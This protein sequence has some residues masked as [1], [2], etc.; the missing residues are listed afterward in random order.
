MPTDMAVRSRC[1]FITMQE[2]DRSDLVRV[3]DPRIQAEAKQLQRR[4]LR[5]RLE[6]LSR[7]IRDVVE[8]GLT[9]RSRD[10]YET[11]AFAISDEPERC[12]KLAI[13]LGDREQDSRDV[14]S[15]SEAA[16]V[17]S[18]YH[19]LHYMPDLPFVFT[20]VLS[21]SASV[22]LKTIGEKI[23]LTPHMTGR[24]LRRLGFERSTRT[25]GGYAVTLDTRLRR[26]VH[27]LLKR[28]GIPS[29]FAKI[30]EI[31]FPDCKVCEELKVP[32]VFEVNPAEN[33]P[34]EPSVLTARGRLEPASLLTFVKQMES[35]RR[36]KRKK[37]S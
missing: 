28:Y 34:S 8:S 3:S 5:L 22:A 16:I 11:L 9:S 30:A 7:S 20:G 15:S 35:F 27:L 29:H 37:A 24:I 19:I 17:V 21:G 13:L 23:V 4:F 2:T 1:V 6:K 14:L 32:K 10:L 33:N 31:P 25:N 36:R 12:K 18:L 26:S